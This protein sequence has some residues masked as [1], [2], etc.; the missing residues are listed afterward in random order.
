MPTQSDLQPVHLPRLANA[1]EQLVE[2][3]KP[4]LFDPA[5]IT[6]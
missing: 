5:S 2:R 6:V 4:A 3:C 1:A